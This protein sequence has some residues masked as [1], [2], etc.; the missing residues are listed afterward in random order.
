MGLLVE[1]SAQERAISAPMVKPAAAIHSHVGIA[2]HQRISATS[3][4]APLPPFHPAMYTTLPRTA[5]PIVGRGRVAGPWTTAPL[6]ALN[7]LP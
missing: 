4:F 7:W 2:R 3:R 5:T 6:T 1:A